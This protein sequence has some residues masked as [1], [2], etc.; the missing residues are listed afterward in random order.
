MFCSLV[1][2]AELLAY[3]HSMSMLPILIIHDLLALVISLLLLLLLLFCTMFHLHLKISAMSHCITWK[4]MWR[5]PTLTG[6]WCFWSDDEGASDWN[7]LFV[8]IA[9]DWPSQKKRCKLESLAGFFG[10]WWPR[11]NANRLTLTARCCS[12]K[13]SSFKL[14]GLF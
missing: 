10:E 14:P 11:D 9:F 5:F 8:L 3:C 12:V 2:F 13:V 4:Y 7:M 6:R 1:Y